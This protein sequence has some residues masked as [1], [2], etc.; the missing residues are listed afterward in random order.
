MLVLLIMITLSLLLGFIALGTNLS[1]TI[2]EADNKILFWILY[3]VS[4]LTIIQLIICFFF[5]FKYKNKVGPLGPH[6]FMGERGDRGDSGSCGYTNTNTNKLTDN[7]DISC[8]HKTFE[9]LMI[10]I[11][12][13]TLGRELNNNELEDIYTFVYISNNESHINLTKMKNKDIKAFN[14]YLRAEI[15]KQIEQ[16]NNN[17]GSIED[18]VKKI[19]ENKTLDTITNTIS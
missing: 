4:L 1:N 6:G 10:K 13:D 5:F 11:F 16:I 2:K 18:I 17:Y 12:S 15:E 9:I 3:V 7:T 14:I 8:R 19:L